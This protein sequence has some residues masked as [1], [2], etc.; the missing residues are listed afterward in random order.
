MGT[1]LRLAW[2]W[3]RRLDHRLFLKGLVTFP[4][5]LPFMPVFFAMLEGKEIEGEV[6][7]Y[8]PFRL[9][10]QAYLFRLG[11]RWR[12]PKYAVLLDDLPHVP[13]R[14]FS[15]RDGRD[16]SVIVVTSVPI[17]Q[18][19]PAHLYRALL[20]SRRGELAVNNLLHEV[21][22]AGGWETGVSTL[23][24]EI[25]EKRREADERAE[26]R[27]VRIAEARR[28]FEAEYPDAVREVTENA[29]EGQPPLSVGQYESQFLAVIA[30]AVVAGL[31]FLG[32]AVAVTAIR[33]LLRR[34][35]RRTRP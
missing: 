30:A 29:P 33:R 31:P 23:P 6:R 13:F 32:V 22:V 15:R 5:V 25:A 12:L 21:A 19:D 28:T 35:R 7:R 27:R 4:V 17:A 24:P 2:D 14:R 8:G 9:H 20:Q 18:S 16:D 34:A 3:W 11:L 10:P 1:F 26:T